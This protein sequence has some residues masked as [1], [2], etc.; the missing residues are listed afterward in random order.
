MLE[1]KKGRERG[2]EKEGGKSVVK[3]EREGEIPT[4]AGNSYMP[5]VMGIGINVSSVRQDN[6]V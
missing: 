5:D 2:K 6:L 3:E 1:R 4:L